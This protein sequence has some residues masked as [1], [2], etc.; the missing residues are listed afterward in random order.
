MQTAEAPDLRYP[1]GRYRPPET[2][3][4]AQ[5]REWIETLASAPAKFRMAVAGLR[6]EQLD[7]PYR[8]GGWTI[9]QVI[10]HVPDSHMNSYMRFRLALTEDEPTIKPYHENLWA[11]LPD[12][13]SS[14][15]EPSL[16]LLA[17]LHDRWVTLL[18]AMT[19]EQFQR[20]FRHPEIGLINLEW[21]LGLYD[22][23]CRHHLAHIENLKARMGW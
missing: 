20:K 4:E 14:P 2:I 11:E 13:K 3:T 6:A 7:T 17:A 15:I 9:R 1:V 16:E 8:P 22:W 23:H 5:R 18:R 12:A 19:A 21:T 10:H